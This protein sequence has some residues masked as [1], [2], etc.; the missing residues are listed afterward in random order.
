MEGNKA[1]RLTLLEKPHITSKALRMFVT[2]LLLFCQPV[3]KQ[4]ISKQ[5]K[6][7]NENK[8]IQNAN[9]DIH[10]KKLPPPLQ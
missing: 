2:L 8:H 10:D 4:D 3:A 1:S 9:A 6:L 5:I 7:I